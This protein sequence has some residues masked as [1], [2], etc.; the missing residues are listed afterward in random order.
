MIAAQPHALHPA[1]RKIIEAATALSAV[2]A[3]AGMYRLAELPRAAD[4][5]WSHVDVLVVPTYPRPRE[6]G[7]LAADPFGPNSELGTYTNFV[8][9]LDLCALAIPSRFRSDGFPS[10]VTLIAPR[11]RDG[12]LAA[13]GERLHAASAKSI[14]ATP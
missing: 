9:L 13:L 11:G 5:I 8:N 14:G 7:E 2:D 1:T 4:G 3:F 12:L 10:G 6:V